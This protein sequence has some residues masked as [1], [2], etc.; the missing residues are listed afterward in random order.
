MVGASVH[1]LPPRRH[2]LALA[3]TGSAKL[4]TA[5][6]S[7]GL[8]TGKAD[9]SVVAEA[10]VPGKVTP[11]AA[12]GPHLVGQTPGLYLRGRAHHVR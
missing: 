8:G 2:H 9:Y 1:L 11:F 3:L 12:G 7:R 4:P 5:S 6:A 10:A